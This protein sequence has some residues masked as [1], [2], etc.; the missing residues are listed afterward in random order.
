ME[1]KYDINGITLLKLK[2]DYYTMDCLIHE[3]E[4]DTLSNFAEILDITPEIFIG[5]FERWSKYFEIA[6]TK[7]EIRKRYSSVIADI[8]VEHHVSA[9]TDIEK[10]NEV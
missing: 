1:R 4:T 9:F 10:H 2:K 5:D 8:Y 3:G 7:S 6:D